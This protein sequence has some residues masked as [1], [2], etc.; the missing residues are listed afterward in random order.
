V[1]PTL[2]SGA[3]VEVTVDACVPR[4]YTTDPLVLNASATSDTTDPDS[5][6]DSATQNVPLIASLFADGF[7]CP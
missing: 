3:S 1:F 5:G 7:D 4:D 2:A 6:N